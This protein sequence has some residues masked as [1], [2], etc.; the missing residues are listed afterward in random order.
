MTVELSKS[1]KLWNS[2]EDRESGDDRPQ[3]VVINYHNGY[4]NAKHNY[5]MNSVGCCFAGWES[6][7]PQGRA[8]Y[9][10][11]LFNQMVTADGMTVGE[12]HGGL[13]E[14]KEY[15]E[16]HDGSW[17][18]AEDLSETGY[19]NPFKDLHCAYSQLVRKT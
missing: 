16:L 5:L 4:R 2:M 14:I 15:R 7:S 1:M 19:T 6:G 11:H 8:A 3:I 13:M 10:M 12:V 9:V 18:A 17:Q